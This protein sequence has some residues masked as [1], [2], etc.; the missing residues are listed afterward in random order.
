MNELVSRYGYLRADVMEFS[1]RQL[2]MTLRLARA[3]DREATAERLALDRLA[4]HGDAK[5]VDRT[6]KD[7]RSDKVWRQR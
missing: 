5:T 4:Q 1:P 3:D 2:E 6:M 7:L